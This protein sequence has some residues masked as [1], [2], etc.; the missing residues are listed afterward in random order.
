MPGRSFTINGR[1]RATESPRE[2]G[3]WTV[4]DTTTGKLLARSVRLVADLASI[5]QRVPPS[6]PAGERCSV[7]GSVLQPVCVNPECTEEFA[8]TFPAPG[9]QGV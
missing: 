5:V 2:H 4:Y 1:L 8:E 6:Q 3:S 9:H 7:C